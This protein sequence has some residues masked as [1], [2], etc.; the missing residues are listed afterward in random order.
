MTNWKTHTT[1]RSCYG[2]KK[3]SKSTEVQTAE[4]KTVQVLT[5]VRYSI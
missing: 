1:Q 4:R 5:L 2:S 3:L